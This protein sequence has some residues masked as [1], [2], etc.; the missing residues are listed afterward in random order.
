M[1]TNKQREVWEDTA[2]IGINKESAHCT[3]V[4][5]ADVASALVPRQYT[6]H[7]R[8]IPSPYYKT[9]DGTWKF[10]WVKRPADRP[11][12]FW[13][14]TYDDSGWGDIPVPSNWQRHGH[15]IPIYTNV[16]YPYSIK[17]NKD[18]IPGIDHEYNQIGRAHV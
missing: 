4:P 8:N 18:E 12:D 15:G 1:S 9:L 14:A 11:R 17:T 3:L 7:E 13:Q 5:F 16:T 6:E 10:H 2:V